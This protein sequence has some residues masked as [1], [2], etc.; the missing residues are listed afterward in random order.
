VRVVVD[1]RPARVHA[2]FACL[3][4]NEILD[5]PAQRVVQMNVGHGL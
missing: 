2:D 5:F 4:R 1:R 3:L